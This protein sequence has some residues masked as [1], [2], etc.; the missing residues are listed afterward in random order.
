MI[1]RILFIA[2]I[3]L[4]VSYTY[5]Q[6]KPEIINSGEIL[7]KGYEFYEKEKYE[8]AITE[9]KKIPENDT[10]YYNSIVEQVLTYY[11]LKKYNEG[12][13]IGQKGLKCKLDL[14]PEIFMN[15]GACLDM[16]EKYSDAVKLYDEGLKIFPLNNKIWY[17]KGFSYSKLEKY[18]EFLQ[19]ISKPYIFLITKHSGKF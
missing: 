15:I 8:E 9:F 13:E 4:V 14:S 5:S 2:I 6:V 17:N 7:K 12:V 3:G 10:N 11:Q 1:K 19:E 18:K 16:L